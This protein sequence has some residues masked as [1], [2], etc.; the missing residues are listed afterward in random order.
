LGNFP[1]PE[2]SQ[3]QAEEVAETTNA[4]NIK[5]YL[6]SKFCFVFYVGDLKAKCNS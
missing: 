3:G 5:K 4:L 2:S 6:S 1:T